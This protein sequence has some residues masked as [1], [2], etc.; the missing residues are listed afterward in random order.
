[1]DMGRG[2]P[3]TFMA[4]PTGTRVLLM[5][6]TLVVMAVLAV[7]ADDEDMYDILGLGQEREDA[8]EK[9]IKSN[10]R[11]LS[12]EHHPDLKGESSREMYKKI[13][14]AYEVLSDRKKRK[15][16][17]MRGEEGLKQLEKA[18]SQQ[19]QQHMDP[20]ARM[21]GGGGGQ[22]TQKTPNVDMVLLCTLEDAYSG[23][24]HT[25]RLNKQRLCKKCRGTGAA[26]KA[27]FQECKTC[28]G[29]GHVVQRVQLAPGFV[30]QVQQP[31]QRCGGKG[32]TIK[33][34]CERCRGNKVGR[35]EQELSI[36]IEVGTPEGH[37][38]VFDM[39]ADQS[40]DAIPGDVIFTVQTKNHPRF[41]RNGRD[42][43]LTVPLTLP[44]ALLGFTKTV[45]HLDDH[46][47]VLTE[48]GIT[49]HGTRRK[50]AGEG[51]PIHNVPS[52]KGDLYVTYTVELPGVLTQKQREELQA[53]FPQ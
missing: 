40:P 50:I 27:D 26:S 17:D 31:C 5:A 11:K 18:G 1:M 2:W 12:R 8:T 41:K 19:Q 28:G 46:S 49:N 22:D 34:K 32:K 9:Q 24:S 15:V 6:A 29:R 14:R 53:V 4:G 21:F 33:K 36:E 20:F 7:A 51:M 48:T 16:Y 30:Q 25:V 35:V 13:Q 52:E 37:K 39:E 3:D 38:I 47:V 44:Q 43:E 42:L 10:W 45:P 23:A